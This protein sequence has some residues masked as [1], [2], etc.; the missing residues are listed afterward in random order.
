MATVPTYNAPQVAQQVAPAAQFSMPNAP[1]TGGQQARQAAE[2]MQRAG[3]AISA[4]TND[5]QTRAN[6]SVLDAA[7]SKGKRAAMIQSRGFQQLQGEDALRPDPEGS[8][9]TKAFASNLD[10]ELNEIEKGLGNDFQRQ[11]FAA[12]RQ[13]VSGEFDYDTTGHQITQQKVFDKA[14]SL[15]NYEVAREQLLTS[16]ENPERVAESL[17][18]IDASIARLHEGMP[19]DYI[20]AKQREARDAAH[21]SVITSQ[22]AKGSTSGARSYF[23]SVQASGSPLGKAAEA[24]AFQKISAAADEDKWRTNSDLLI[25]QHGSDIDAALKQTR[26]DFEAGKITGKDRTAIESRYLADVDH[27]RVAEK[28]AVEPLVQPIQM[29]IAD[30]DV[31]Q[32]YISTSEMDQLL[33]PLANHP[34][35]RMEWAERLANQNHQIKARRQ[36]D[37]SHWRSLSLSDSPSKQAQELAYRIDMVKNPDKYLGDGF[38]DTIAKDLKEGKLT[39]SG[40]E[41]LTGL[42]SGLRKAGAK[43]AT[44]ADKQHFTALKLTD[45]EIE[46]GA[47][48]AGIIPKGK[49]YAEFAKNPNADLDRYADFRA[50]VELR[51]NEVEQ[52]TGKTASP[53]EVRSVIDGVL[54]D[55]VFVPGR[56]W[57][58]GGEKRAL[59]SLSAE[60][61][62]RAVVKLGKDEVRLAEIPPGFSAQAMESLRRR[63]LPVTSESIAAEWL[64]SKK[65]NQ[66]GF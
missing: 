5:M 3:T 52:R 62:A 11:Q 25:T 7:F 44:A 9:P 61:Q 30:A 51:V 59:A 19:A 36:S 40:A 13:K 63:G 2:G 20:A 64:A 14:S 58:F 32:R 46:R 15:G 28:M 50:S 65:Q 29:R 12:F 35:A 24:S 57:G 17:G 49:T 1:D 33:K 27:K 26:A 21:E 60:E 18:V 45:D 39:S 43:E 54:K 4:I 38:G 48:G 56:M 10:S 41:Q 53:A 42:W 47:W 31:S 66:K 34:Q 16:P 22:L 23:D 8:P 37:E 55:Q 6:A